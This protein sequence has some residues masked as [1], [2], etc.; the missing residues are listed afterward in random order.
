MEHVHDIV[1]GLQ[2]YHYI[3]PSF[4]IK[5]VLVLNTQQHTIQNPFFYQYLMSVKQA[6]Y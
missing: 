2:Y 5:K 6:M 1:K 3:L 4:K